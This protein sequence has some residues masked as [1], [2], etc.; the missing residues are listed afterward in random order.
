MD[1][2]I[3]RVDGRGMQLT[4]VQR[5]LINEG[6]VV[7]DHER[8]LQLGEDLHFVDGFALLLE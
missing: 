5:V 2:F 6:V 8:A 4:N 3:V 1:E 7:S